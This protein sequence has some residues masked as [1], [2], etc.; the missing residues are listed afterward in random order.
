VSNS[1]QGRH[2][3]ARRGVEEAGFVDAGWEFVGGVVVVVAAM[4]AFAFAPRRRR[5]TKPLS[6]VDEAF[7]KNRPGSTRPARSGRPPPA[8]SPEGA[9]RRPRP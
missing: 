1:R 2:R 8:R 3:Q 4:V 9:R 7:T 5:R 6:A